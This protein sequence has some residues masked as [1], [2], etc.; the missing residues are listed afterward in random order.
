MDRG[1]T[2]MA[3]GNFQKARVEFQS[4]LQVMPDDAEARFQ[5][6]RVL[7]RLG[8]VREAGRFFAGAIEADPTHEPARA[9]L[10]RLYLYGGSPQQALATLEPA[11][12]TRTTNAAVLAVAAAAKFALKDVDGAL[13]AAEKAHAADPRSELATATLAG[14][15]GALDRRADALRVLEEG[16]RIN[17]TSTEL[18]LALAQELVVAGR[19]KD[20]ERHLRSLLDGSRSTPASWMRLASFYRAQNRSADVEKTLREAIATLPSDRDVSMAFITY[21]AETRGPGA[22]L[23]ELEAIGAANPNSADLT[24]AVGPYLERTDPEAAER[25]YRDL[26]AK[27]GAEAAGLKARVR[28]A[29]LAS[30]RGE[31]D[32]ADA[33]IADVLRENPRDA[34]ALALRS[35]R[36]AAAGD[37]QGAIADLRTVLRDDP[38]NPDFLLAIARAHITL[39][40][41]ALAEEAIR[42]GLDADPANVSLQLALAGLLLERDEAAA[43]V[44][45]L[46]QLARARPVDR[47]VQDALF[48]ASMRVN[49][50]ALADATVRA[51]RSTFA[52]S[53]TTHLYAGM[54]AEA[55]GNLADAEQA[56]RK[57]VG[58]APGVAEPLM[59][60]AGVYAKQGRTDQAVAMLEKEAKRAPESPVPH[61][62]RGDLLLASSRYSEAEAAY[63]AAIR[64]APSWWPGYRGLAQSLTGRKQVDAA[65][66]ALKEG[67][68]RAA[69]PTELHVELGLLGEQQSRWTDAAGEYEKVLARNPSHA[70][71]RNNLAMILATHDA[72]KENLRRADELVQ[73]FAQ[74]RDSRLVDTFG[75]VQLKLGRNREAREAFE[76]TVAMDPS[77]GTYRYHLGLALM[78][79]GDEQRA[80][81]EIG[82]AVKSDPDFVE[83]Q[84]ARNLLAALAGRR[85]QDVAS[86]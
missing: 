21:V 24:L 6:G 43:A 55:R 31:V 75:W 42:R 36:R 65:R 52:E 47:Q 37:G 76:R 77:N 30:R 41:G 8:D 56:Y 9:A 28:L 44:S 54:V 13:A 61:K 22:A 57:A 73:P 81:E 20:A 3:E 23:Q 17:P 12:A 84:S 19:A 53:A 80:A 85:A 74:A 32:R 25:L 45:L 70:V 67:A 59:A 58:L 7:D 68:E 69:D 86:N 50:L 34:G 38:N 15:Y 1:S 39:G 62:L 48:R 18:R 82:R 79:E 66:A 5:N 35:A 60:T 46:T 83:V 2:Y 49:D 16:V 14:L 51:I 40:E 29:E 78:A 71:A 72:S 63:R 11:L 26:V 33:M 10:A 27:S 64:T 4:A